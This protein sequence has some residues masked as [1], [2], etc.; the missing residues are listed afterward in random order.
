MLEKLKEKFTITVNDELMCLDVYAMQKKFP[1]YQ[2]KFD[3]FFNENNEDPD[4]ILTK[5]ISI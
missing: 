3:L 5:D 2:E 1:F 4:F